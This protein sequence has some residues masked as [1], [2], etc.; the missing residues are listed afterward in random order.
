MIARSTLLI[1]ACLL[2]SLVLSGVSALFAVAAQ[3]GTYRSWESPPVFDYVYS[4][5]IFPCS[6]YRYGR[7][8]FMRNTANA[9]CG[10]GAPSF[11]LTT[12]EP[13]P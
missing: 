4:V 6:E 13:C 10:T 1:M 7:L 11:T 5:T 3:S 2:I 12:T 9:W 8:W